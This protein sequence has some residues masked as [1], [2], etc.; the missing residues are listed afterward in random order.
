M[1]KESVKKIEYGDFQ[2]P[3]V[4]ARQVCVLLKNQKIIPKSVIEPTCGIGNFFLEALGNF[5]SIQI[6]RAFD[7]DNEYVKILKKN[8]GKDIKFKPHKVEVVDFFTKDWKEELGNLPEP[9]LVIGNPPWVTNSQLGQL[10]SKNLPT[11]YNFKRMKGLDAMTGKSN[12]DISEWMM[13]QMI[14]W[15]QVKQAT[16][17]LKFQKMGLN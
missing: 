15:L 3:R 11:K 16:I 6:G 13:N 9:I 2:T 1:T 8:L 10:Q 12:F 17:G 5:S 14:D 7:I 4:L